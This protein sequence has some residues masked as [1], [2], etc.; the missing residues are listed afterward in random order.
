E[1]D[2]TT[3]YEITKNYT[4]GI[5]YTYASPLKP[6]QPFIKNKKMVSPWFKVIKE[7]DLN[8]IPNSISANTNL[9]RYYYELQSRDLSSTTS[10]EFFPLTV[11]KNFLWNTDLA[12]NWNLTKNLKLYFSMNNRAKVEE[13]LSTPVNKELF[14]TEYQNWKDTVSRSIR[15]FGTPLEYNQTVNLTW[16][17]PLN[18]IPALDF[19]TLNTQYNAVYDWN[20]SATTQA[21][22][23]DLGNQV[24]NQR[25]LSLS[26]SANLL[27]LYNKS[28]FLKKVNKKMMETNRS[29]LPAKASPQKNT[30]GNQPEKPVVREQKKYEKEIALFKDS[31]VTVRHNLKNKRVYVF[32]VDSAGRRISV[33]YR[34]KD[35][36]NLLV[37]GN[38]KETLKLTV[39]QK[40][41]LD[42]EGWY[43]VAQVAARTLMSVRNISLTY[44]E[45]DGMTLP[46]FIPESGLFRKTD[47][48]TAPGW[49]FALGLQSDDYL[50][51]ALDKN[52]LIIADSITSPVMVT[53]VM[54]LR[55]KSSIEP[56]PGLRIDFNAVR[57][58]NYNT[59]IQYMYEGMPETK[60]GSFTM[61]TIALSTAFG[62]SKSSD[63]YFSKSFQ[64]F[65]DNREIVAAR[66]EKK[67]IGKNYP[68][69][70]FLSGTT[71]ADQPYDAQNGAFDLNSA[72][73][74]IPAFLAA[75]T[76]KDV[77]SS[78]LDLFPS[79]RALLPNW[80]IS[81]DGLSRIDFIK[82][83]FRNVT[84]NHAYTCTY[85]VSSFA[86]YSTFVDAGGGLGYVRDV[87]TGNPTPS[88]MYDVSS[89]T[90]IEA[91]NPLFRIQGT[92]LNGWTF[93][94][95]WRKSRSMNLSI[96][97]GQVV[98]ANQDQFAVG[99]NYK[100]SDFHP[101]GFL[102]KS[103]LKNDLGMSGKLTY[104]NQHA[105]L[106]KIEQNYTQASSGNKTFVMELMGDY[107]ISKNMS[108]TLFYDLES[109]VPLVSSY[110]V[111]SS[112]F[113]F[114][115]RFSLNR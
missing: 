109:T 93:N 45:T 101:W 25:V 4:G 85:N 100:I 103:K 32:A 38:K 17:V 106:R 75:Y 27:M 114:S 24:S 110:P 53:K 78:A 37:Y 6:W 51:K 98:E 79:L 89:V 3:E 14:A 58:W 10:D 54:D 20:R 22:E 52:W 102:K 15:E 30:A 29:T 12:L 16:Q 44:K 66:L 71:L 99:T 61:T 72:D 68:N 36:N 19:M 82:K 67:M 86:S 83:Y 55:M 35:E 90:L 63:G 26:S 62:S 105:L 111:T 94:T 59:Q 108:M 48:G 56:L 34:I 2:A 43:K 76:G 21:T 84:L 42:G 74:L 11:S 92:L 1:R 112:D 8:F 73:V 64:K 23:T 80:S 28:D 95:E 41:S 77:K 47:L 113:G 70:G 57:S 104:K 46:G 18:R 91:F 33:K 39:I 88:S 31:V 49:D 9:N 13:T 115:I 60:T 7:L 107:T 81:Y 40:P 65:L 96:S 5:N 97:G 69:S 87:L 50:K